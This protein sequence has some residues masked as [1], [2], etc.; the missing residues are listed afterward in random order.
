V[1]VPKVT[2][3]QLTRANRVPLGIV[4]NALP[5]NWLATRPDGSWWLMEERTQP[6]VL[7]VLEPATVEALRAAKSPV[8]LRV[9]L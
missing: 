7:A 2:R 8:V 3:A 4:A 9:A 1:K 5:E 6:V